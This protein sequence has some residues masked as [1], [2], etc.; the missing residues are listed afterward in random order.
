MTTTVYFSLLQ[1]INSQTVRKHLNS[2]ISYN[3]S[4]ACFFN[5]V[6]WLTRPF[7]GE[8]VS[9]HAAWI[10]ICTWLGVG[11]RAATSPAW[12][13]TTWRLTSGTT[14]HLCRSLWL[15]MQE[16][17]TTARSTYQVRRDPVT[18]SDLHKYSILHVCHSTKTLFCVYGLQEEFTM[19]SMFPGST[20]MT[21]LWMC[22]LGNRIWTQSAPFML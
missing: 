6:V 4:C 8:P 10:S 1:I 2:E 21:L 7:S 9:S 13:P 20:V 11:T 16:R 22:G 5:D 17:Y 18:Y 19:E 3:N 15:R 12:S 14:C